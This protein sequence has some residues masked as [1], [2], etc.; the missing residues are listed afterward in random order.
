MRITLPDRRERRDEPNNELIEPFI[1]HALSL[2]KEQ[3]LRETNLIRSASAPF[4]RILFDLRDSLLSV[5]SMNRRPDIS[6]E[7]AEAPHG[8]MFSGNVGVGKTIAMRVM[9]GAIGGEYLTMPDLG[10]KFAQKEAAG[11]WNEVDSAGSWD[12]FLD[13]LGAESQIKKFGNVLPVEELLYKRYNL[14]QQ[15]GVRTHIT[16]NLTG[17]QFADRYGNRV[18]D[19]L[20]E[21]MYPVIDSGASLRKKQG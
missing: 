5:R 18:R 16:T 1:R 20:R 14:W 10:A 21:M 13:D 17:D 4:G 2:F 12:L 7:Y 9:A 8:V 15:R 11:F 6:K 19:R 3:G